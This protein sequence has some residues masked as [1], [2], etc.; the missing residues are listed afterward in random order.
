MRIVVTG[1]DGAL[2]RGVAARL[3]SLTHDVV[4]IG[5]SR[6]ESWPGSVDFVVSDGYDA[7]VLKGADAVLHCATN[8]SNLVTLLDAVAGA[9]VGR[10]AVV[11][12][13]WRCDDADS[14]EA[15][16]A[17]SGLQ[18]IIVRT[19]LVLGRHV[20]DAVLRTFSG[21]VV[22]DAD[23]SADQPLQVVHAHDVERVLV[24]A[25]L[26]PDLPVGR[27]DLAAVGHTTVRAIAAAVGRPVVGIPGPLRRLVSTGRAKQVRPYLDTTALRDDWRFTPGYDVAQAIEDFALACRG[28]I[29]IG[30]SVRD[31]PWR[32]PRV[33]EIPAVD[34]PAPDGVAP[35]PAGQGGANGEFDTPI[36]PR[37]PAFIAT[38]LSE[39]LAGPFSPSSAS[40]TVLGTR[41][42]GLVISER[43]RP[44]GAVQREM[45][46]RTTG[47]FGHR[48]YA[49]ITTGHFMAHTVPF[50]DPNLVLS[51]F[52]G[53]TEDGLELFGEH[54]PPVEPRGL[55]RQLR[56]GLTFANCLIGLS[57]GSHR[58]TKDFVGDVARLESAAQHPTALSD[59][60]LRE[61]I[62]LGRDHVVHGWVLS[63]ASI[64]LC[65]GYGVVMRLLCGRDVM[66]AA[67]DELVSAQALSAVHRLAAA[68]RRDP[69]A[70]RLL[71]EPTIDADALAAQAP[72]FSA[73]LTRELA[74][75]GHR[76]PGEVEMRCATYADDPGLLIRMVSKAL[77]ATP[78]DL[79]VLPQVPLRARAVAVA[80]ASQIREREV[81]RDR[82][83]R[84]IWVLRGLLREQG[85]RMVDAGELGA[86]DDVFYLLVD[87][88]DASPPDLAGIV[89]RRR[90]EQVALQELVTPEAFSGHWLPSNG[91]GDAFR[92]GE[93][94][95][96]IGVSGG[97]VRGLVRVV[98]AETIDDLQPGEILVAKV[99]DVGYTPAFAYAAA[100][101][102]EL[103][104]PTS[105]A[106][107]VAR[108]FGVPCVVNARGAAARLST[109]TLI[110]VDG[111]TGDVTVLGA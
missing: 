49:G 73:A 67:G 52:F 92:G 57:A 18:A 77:T 55:F 6:P 32:L 43:L 33:L 12:P 107:I 22:L 65:A 93:V 99:T 7:D 79:P 106:A 31:I 37:F 39:A 98:H 110:E 44:G 34:A 60:R 56:G 13:T 91:P 3:V 30:A 100:V 66:P 40:V 87:E 61:L 47:V 69:V 68:A 109:G 36:D 21:A 83:V 62:L 20:D 9:D 11:S 94:L 54:L 90:A 35:V 72:G 89:T 42:A 84:A 24:R 48:L 4:G 5:A 50:I 51:G 80:A 10:L 95:H 76:G 75:I 14:I 19:A 88:L 101:V 104:G 59:R 53:H 17:T 64:L 8:A 15:G 102:T 28:R 2:G 29:T 96:G 23:G 111:A 74:L 27:V 81:R 45:S 41:A 82:M 86:I 1:A 97:R 46:V 108:E 85:R 38:N 105:H 103:G 25:A 71:A 63:S 16:V 78:R 70:A 58:D 26:D